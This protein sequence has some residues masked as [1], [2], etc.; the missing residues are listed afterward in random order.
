MQLCL[1]E[2]GNLLNKYQTFIPHIGG[3]FPQFPE[4]PD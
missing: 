3:L 4:Q 1:T 2:K